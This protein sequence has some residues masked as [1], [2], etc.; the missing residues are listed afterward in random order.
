MGVDLYINKNYSIAD[1]M[2]MGERDISYIARTLD[3]G[4]IGIA[5]DYEV[6]G[7]HSDDV[8]SNTSI[9]PSI[10]DIAA[11]TSI[12]HSFDLQV[13]YRVLFQIGSHNGES[14]ILYPSNTT[15]W[16]DSL[17]SAEAPALK[18]AQQ[19]G[20]HEFIVGTE[21]P[22]VEGSPLWSQFFNAAGQMYHGILSYAAWGGN[23]G[24]NGFFSAGRKL[25]PVV[26]YGATA[27]PYV[28]LPP[29]ASVSQLTQAW[30]KFL[31]TVPSPVLQLT[32]IDEVGIPATVGAYHA[33]WAWNAPKGAIDGQV[34]ARWFDAVC[35]AAGREHMRA[36]YFWNVNLIDDPAHPFASPV[37]FEARPA[38]ETAIRNCQQVANVSAEKG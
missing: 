13:E 31:Q 4:A 30:E 32:A 35:A 1:T 14:E 9:T 3:V 19:D 7:R 20:V 29:D 34:Q 2:R 38:S 18:L 6:P 11:L 23:P 12:A 26:Y 37:K 5:W 10:A 25:M 24:E 22:G 33:P 36:I 28:D 8:E 17:L 15:T 21:L 16:L 27:Y